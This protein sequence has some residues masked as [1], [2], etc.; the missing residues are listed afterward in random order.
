MSLM[1]NENNSW[2]FELLRFVALTYNDYNGNM[3]HS[4]SQASSSL[5]S[6]IEKSA[7]DK[8]R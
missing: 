8:I 2:A 3:L 7:R 4:G 5:L 6:P 1:M